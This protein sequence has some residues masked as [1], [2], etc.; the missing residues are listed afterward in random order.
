MGGKGTLEARRR[1]NARHYA[2]HKDKINAE[3]KAA[4]KLKPKRSGEQRERHREGLKRWYEKH[5]A[6]YRVKRR[7]REDERQ[8]ATS[9]RPHQCE[10]CGRR[11]GR[12]GIALDHCHQTGR[13]RGWL[14]YSCNTILGHAADDPKILRGLAAYLER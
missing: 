7:Q 9:P 14:C 10:V 13:F 1:A 8:G 11:N 6:A 2:R 5:G 12:W 3:R 4:Y